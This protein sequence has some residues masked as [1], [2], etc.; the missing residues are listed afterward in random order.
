MADTPSSILLLR[1]QSTGSNVNLW[2]GYLNTALQTL[3]QASK[4]YQTLVVTADA[5]INWTQYAT[6]NIG[7]CAR[8]KLTGAIASP[9]TLTFPSYMNHMSVEN[10]AGAQVTVKCSGGTGVA[11]ASGSKATVYCDGVDYYNAAP[12]VFPTGDVTFAG[13][14]RNVTAATISTDVPNLTQVQSLIAA[15]GFPG[16]PGTVK[17]DPLAASQYL[18]D[19]ALP[20]YGI[21]IVDNGDSMTW[22]VDLTEI[23]EF[24]ATVGEITST[25]LNVSTPMVSGR[26]YLFTGTGP[27]VLPTL[28]VG[29]FVEVVFA[30]ASGVT[31]TVGRNGQT[32]DGAAADDTWLGSGGK[33]GPTLR[34]EY[35][36]SGAVKSE[37]I[38][39][40]PL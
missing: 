27:A 25:I 3:E 28:G 21:D 35:A 14:L 40:V 8:L 15:G 36:S 5:T 1:L 26:R 23:S 31:G 10:T 22:D 37:L 17:V 38:G 11:I 7:Q 34:Y 39:S 13:R 20:G 6:G 32:I 19:A 24:N 4:G 33:S 29:G 16:A 2:G 9:A 30:Q 12:T 18:I